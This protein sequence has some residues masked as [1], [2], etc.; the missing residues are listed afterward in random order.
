MKTRKTKPWPT[1]NQTLYVGDL[2]DPLE[3]TL[4]EAIALGDKVY[5]EGL[6]YDGFDIGKTALVT[7]F[8]PSENLS[9]EHLISNRDGQGRD[10]FNQILT[11]AFQLGFEQGRR[12]ILS[13]DAPGS[14]V[15]EL[16]RHGWDM[17][18]LQRDLDVFKTCKAL[19]D[20]ALDRLKEVFKF[21]Q[22]KIIFGFLQE[23]P[24]AEKV[25][26][27]VPETL[28]PFC[29][30]A[31]FR[32]QVHTE[33]GSGDFYVVM[34]MGLAYAQRKAL[35]DNIYRAWDSIVPDSLPIHLVLRKRPTRAL[36]IPSP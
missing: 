9:A 27:S 23:Y 25:L 12:S 32:L 26:L 13:D 10:V 15:W 5:E 29:T 21:S 17:E 11:L 4:Q 19:E 30:L 33:D 18:K 1:G 8:S 20:A 6:S 24:E 16:A 36:T 2:L 22:P 14:L 28:R 35:R 7:C 34:E 3:K 31:E